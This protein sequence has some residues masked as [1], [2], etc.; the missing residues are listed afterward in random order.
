MIRNCFVQEDR[1]KRVHEEQ[2]TAAFNL[3][4]A[5]AVRTKRT[6]KPNDSYVRILRIYKNIIEHLKCNHS[7]IDIIYQLNPI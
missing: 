4:T 3:G 6:S 5:E 1:M 7:Y 2:K